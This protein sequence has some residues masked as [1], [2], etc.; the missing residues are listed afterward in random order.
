MKG[1][2]LWNEHKKNGQDIFRMKAKKMYK[3]CYLVDCPMHQ[4]LG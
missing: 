3:T 2:K 1:I 4:K